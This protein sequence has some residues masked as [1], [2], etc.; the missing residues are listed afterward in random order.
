MSWEECQCS[1]S[2]AAAQ[3]T[4]KGA[5]E[6]KG[7]APPFTHTHT[8]KLD[9]RCHHTG[10]STQRLGLEGSP[11][12]STYDGSLALIR[13]PA[14][15]EEGPGW[16][17]RPRIFLRSKASEREAGEALP[18]ALATRRRV[19]FLLLSLFACSS[20]SWTLQHAGGGCAVPTCH[21][22]IFTD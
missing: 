9:A 16:V 22:S 13:A 1:V 12:W 10:H 21:T 20:P 6:R 18:I 3:Q 15:H 2:K 19:H 4:G 14:C 11:R 17:H 5:E 7:E 8:H